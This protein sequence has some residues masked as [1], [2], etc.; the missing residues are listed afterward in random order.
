MNVFEGSLQEASSG[1]ESD[2]ECL[3]YD[4]KPPILR[5]IFEEERSYSEK[6]AIIAKEIYQTAL[7][8]GHTQGYNDLS[9]LSQELER[10]I[11]VSGEYL[12]SLMGFVNFKVSF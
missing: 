6:L 9:L 12:A 10:Y 4:N 7:I 8:D 2:N 3:D 11:G 5:E 1:S